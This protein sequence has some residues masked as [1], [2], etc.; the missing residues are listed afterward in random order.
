[1]AMSREFRWAVSTILQMNNVPASPTNINA[2]NNPNQN[3]QWI[4]A[5]I[6]GAQPQIGSM[7]SG[8]Y[9]KVM[10]ILQANGIEITLYTAGNGTGPVNPIPPNTPQ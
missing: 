2:F 5:I 9:D 7:T 10:N 3:K 6:R 4:N 8:V 1:M